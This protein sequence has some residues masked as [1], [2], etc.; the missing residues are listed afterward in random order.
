MMPARTSQRFTSGMLVML[1]TLTALPA[2]AASLATDVRA[3]LDNPALLRGQFEQ[4]KSVS[5]FKRPLLS[6][7][8]FLF[9][10]GHGVIW[11]TRKPFDATLTL[12]PNKLAASQGGTTTMRLDARREPALLAMNET[13]LALLS[14][15]LGN[16]QKRFYLDGELI[17]QHGWRLRLTPREVGL[18]SI[19]ARVELT[20]DRY[21]RQVQLSEGNG[22]ISNIRFD[23]LN[24]APAASR[25]EAVLLDD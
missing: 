2:H 14:G 10:R 11:H 16:L 15:D 24:E 18:S 13:L 4:S 1:L 5:G 9:W 19:I 22:D 21:V 7:G 23:Q 25:D 8:D 12:T 6:R 3:R 17:G 20:G